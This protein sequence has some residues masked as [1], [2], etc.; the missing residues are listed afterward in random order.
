MKL[1]RAIY[2]LPRASVSKRVLEKN[3]SSKNEFDLHENETV[4]ETHFHMNDFTRR[5]VLAKSTSEIIE[6]QLLR[7]IL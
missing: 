4:G 2:E 6:V 7:G 5:P 3:L 1:N